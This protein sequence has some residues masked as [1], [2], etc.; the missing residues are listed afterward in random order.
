M[1][2]RKKRS[3]P[4]SHAT[5][6]PEQ[7]VESTPGLDE[8]MKIT[9]L[10]AGQEVGRSCCVIE[11]KSTTVVCDTGIHPGFSGMAAL[12]FIDEIDWS[13]VNAILISHFHL[14]HAASLTYIMENT[15]FKEG[16]GK[17]FMTHPTKAVY[18]FLMQDF[19]RMS[20]IGT[21]S[22]LFNEEQMIA[23]YDSIN[24]IDY[25]Q[26][27]SLGSLRFTSYPA[28]HVLGA[29][30][31]LIEINGIRVLY[32]GDYSTEEDRHLIPARVPNWNEK[33]DV[34]IC[35]STYGVQSLEPRCEKEARFTSLVQG[36]LKRG[37]RVLMPVFAL[38]RAQELLLILDEYWAQHPELNQIPIYYI[39]NLAAKCMKVYQTF[40]HGMNDQI[41]HKFNQGINPWTFYREG[42][43]LF[44]KGF[45][46]NLKGIDK[47]EDRGPCVVMASP[48]FMQSGVSRELLE[49]WAPDR[50]NALVITGYSIEGTMAREMQR[51]PAEIIGMKGNKI[52][53]R[54][55]VHYI[56]F[57]AHVDYTQNSAFIDQIMPTH[58]VLVHGELNSM[59]R[60]KNALKDKYLLHKR[61]TQIHTPRNV[62][63]LR[64]TFQASRIARGI[65][66][67]AERKIPPAVRNLGALLVSKDAAYTLL[68]PTDLR[69]YTGLS[70]GTVLQKQKLT[71]N[72]GWQT[73]KWHL[74]RMY[75]SVVEGVDPDGL[76][77]LRVMG[78]VDINLVTESQLL[79]QWVGSLSNDMIADSVLALLLGIDQ[80]PASLKLMLPHSHAHNHAHEQHHE[81][82]LEDDDLKQQLLPSDP[83]LQPRIAKL[84]RL[85]GLLD[86]HFGNVELL[87]AEE[88][89]ITA[90][91][92][93][94]LDD[95]SAQVSL[96][97]FSVE[98]ELEPL[99]I[100][101]AAVFEVALHKISNGPFNTRGCIKQSR[102]NKFWINSIHR[103]TDRQA[104]VYSTAIDMEV[105]FQFN[106]EESHHEAIPSRTSDVLLYGKQE[107]SSQEFYVGHY[108]K[109]PVPPLGRG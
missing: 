38:G 36:I 79:F 56:S 100:R 88:E 57:S 59:T 67:L 54:L 70:T 39:S 20:T 103:V 89:K 71:I 61:D 96:E 3:T 13:T 32:T 101:V 51:E 26:E 29:A 92:R 27:I 65:G 7:G 78:I 58:L 5:A 107:L 85:I 108:V 25:H 30:M 75:G 40:I 69:E 80:S 63:T 12:P 35:E 22:E 8:E 19:V 17:V 105:F 104:T 41:K 86:A 46:T 66:R 99:K 94:W 76:L 44:K 72:V 18:R 45:V 11:Y 55:E 33:P 53:R 73:V 98:S 52:P 68:S 10:G 16:K 83:N 102:V 106:R 62:E 95:V 74:C 37:G 6:V 64:L 28:G 84:D 1:S 9:M 24:A 97:D 15:N 93:V 31:F 50:R 87:E 48:G 42:K 23:S 91:A 109:I 82:K 34:M 2:S 90:R 21:D 77:T 60:L 49:K 14:D 4:N 81:P 47:F 43:G